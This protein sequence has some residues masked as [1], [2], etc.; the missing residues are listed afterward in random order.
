MVVPYFMSSVILVISLVVNLFSC[1]DVAFVDPSTQDGV[2][3]PDR[4]EKSYSGTYCII[5]TGL[6][7]VSMIFDYKLI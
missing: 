4:V 3:H 6:S 2:L 5:T 7:S 1:V